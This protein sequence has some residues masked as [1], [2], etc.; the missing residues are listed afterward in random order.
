MKH[1]RTQTAVKTAIILN[2]IIAGALTAYGLTSS[3]VTITTLVEYAG[4]RKAVL[5]GIAPVWLTLML[6][7]VL[8][9]IE[10]VA[11]TAWY[12]IRMIIEIR[13]DQPR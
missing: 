12:G 9:L 4:M 1:S 7:L 2:I 3:T 6:F 8:S 13:H 11:A 5:T 10:L